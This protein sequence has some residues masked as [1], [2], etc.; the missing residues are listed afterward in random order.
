MSKILHWHLS[1]NKN[2][3][4][5]M[6]AVAASNYVHHISRSTRFFYHMNHDNYPN[7]Y[8]GSD[9]GLLAHEYPVPADS[10]R[11]V[12]RGVDLIHMLHRG[13]LNFGMDIFCYLYE[14]KT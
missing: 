11:L 13:G 9:R 2:S 14:R 6:S 4:G 5:E 12:H 8:S 10:F 7:V 3:L 1:L